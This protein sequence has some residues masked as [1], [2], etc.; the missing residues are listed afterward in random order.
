PAQ[1]FPEPKVRN[2]AW[3]RNPIDS[4]ILARLEREGF[5]PSPEADKVSLIRRLY[6]DLLGLPPEPSEVD[7]FLSD[8]RPDAYERLVE[9][10]LGSPHFGERWGRHWLDLARYADS[11]GYNIDDARE[12]WM[13]RDWVVNALNRDLPFDRFVIEQIAGDLLP[14][15]TLEQLVATGFHR[16]TLINLEGGID[17]EQYRVEAG[18]D[19]VGPTGAVFLGLT[20]GCARCHD[21]KFDPISQ[22]E[23]YQFFAFFNNID[24]LSADKGEEGRKTAH[25]PTLE[26][27]T[28]EDYVRRDAIRSQVAVL[29]K[30][31]DEYAVQWQKSLTPEARLNLR[32]DVRAIVEVPPDQRN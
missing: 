20:L 10:L 12:I 24:E 21:H 19:R 32:P 29:E 9:R 27:G 1:R 31:L 25:K 17:F 6:L 18:V 30:E 15:P 22:R 23:F 11:N 7:A 8:T 13:Y 14:N 16:N 5:S 4:F 2:S 3:V 28:P 26:F